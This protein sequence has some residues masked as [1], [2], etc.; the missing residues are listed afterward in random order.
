MSAASHRVLR[1]ARTESD[2]LSHS[3]SVDTAHL[4]L[5]L[6]LAGDGL[7]WQVLKEAGVEIEGA[8]TGVIKALS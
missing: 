5:G 6:V 4:L 3:R 8:R 7:A 2:L 1:L